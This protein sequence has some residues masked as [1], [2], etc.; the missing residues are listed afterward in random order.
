M[1]RKR[2][3]E[4]PIVVGGVLFMLVVVLFAI[5]APSFLYSPPKGLAKKSQCF[6]NLKYMALGAIMYSDDYDGLAP[7]PSRWMDQTKDY[8][9]QESVYHCPELPQGE[10]GYSVNDHIAGKRLPT[11]P[12]S[13]TWVLF[14]ESKEP[15][16]NAHG[17]PTETTQAFRHENTTSIAYADGHVKSIKRQ[18]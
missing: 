8:T 4:S 15:G 5:L 3:L 9:K 14:F 12:R 10:F 7:T 6:S 11:G 17:V 16:R 13:S 2:A 18:E 1:P